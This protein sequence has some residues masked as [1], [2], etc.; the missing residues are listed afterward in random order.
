MP[1]SLNEVHHPAHMVLPVAIDPAGGSIKDEAVTRAGPHVERDCL[2]PGLLALSQ[3][4]DGFAVDGA[5]QHEPVIIVDML[6]D[7]VDPSRAA[8]SCAGSAP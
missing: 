6:T 2:E 3:C 4:H 8:N 7:Q 1:S 5:G